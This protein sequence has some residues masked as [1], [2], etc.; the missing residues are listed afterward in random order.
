MPPRI[1]AHPAVFSKELRVQT[2][3]L[4]HSERSGISQKSMTSNPSNKYHNSRLSPTAR[5]THHALHSTADYTPPQAPGVPAT[6]RRPCAAGMRHRSVHGRIHSVSEQRSGRSG[7]RL[8]GTT[9]PGTL[10]N[11]ATQATTGSSTNRPSRISCA[12]ISAVRNAAAVMMSRLPAYFGRK[13]PRPATSSHTDT[14]LPS[15]TGP[16]LRV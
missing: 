14:R 7:R 16:F 13:S 15:N 9:L 5:I 2:S 3:K 6:L 12:N 11:C 10:L 8:H 4:Q 1:A